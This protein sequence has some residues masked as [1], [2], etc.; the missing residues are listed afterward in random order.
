MCPGGKAAQDVCP[1]R[2][3][4]PLTDTIYLSNEDGTFT[5]GTEQCG[6]VEGGKG[7]GVLLADFDNDQDVEIYVANDTTVNFLYQNDGRGNLTESGLIHGVAMDDLGTPN[8][9]MGLAVLDYDDNGLP[10]IW[11]TN[12]EEE[13]FALYRQSGNL[14]F[15][16]VSRDTGVTQLENLFVGFGT[17]AAD[18]D[19]DGDEDLAV[20]NGHVVYFPAQHNEA[21]KPVLLENRGG[22]FRQAHPTDEYFGKT[23]H[24]RGLCGGDVNGDGLIDL[25]AV[26]TNQPV[27][28]IVNETAINGTSRR[29]RLIGTQSS[30]VPVGARVVLQLSDRYLVRSVFGGGSYLSQSE[31]WITFGIPSGQHIQKA[32]VYWPSGIQQV[33]EPNMISRETTIVESSKRNDANRFNP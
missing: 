29:F 8:G 26:A 16:H 14:D 3:F 7:L 30:R 6:L 32:T 4:D 27:Q 33:L 28:V 1:P 24:G 5:D 2:A 13:N 20:A 21:Q 31:Q 18:F 19:C 17:V 9:S 10:D 12:F 15:V 22:Q 25:V 11:V 23:H